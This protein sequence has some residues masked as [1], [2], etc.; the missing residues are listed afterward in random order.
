MPDTAKLFGSDHFL[1][2]GTALTV[3]P[4]LRFAVGTFDTWTQLHEVERD[5]RLRTLAFDRFNCLALE[6]LFGGKNVAAASQE[7]A[8]IQ[9]LAFPGNRYPICCTSGPLATCLADQLGAGAPTLREALGHWL[10]P[11]HAAHF[12]KAIEEGKILLW[13]RLADADEERRAYQ[14][15]LAHSS[16]SVGVHDLVALPSAKK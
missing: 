12:Q 13:I 15:L 2:A 14:S 8:N 6:R 11:R 10:V 9:T 5:A 7:L 3:Y 4:D 16:N 1:H